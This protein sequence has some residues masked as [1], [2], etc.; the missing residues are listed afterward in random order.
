MEELGIPYSGPI[1]LFVDNRSAIDY[2]KNST[3]HGRAKHIDIQHHF[4]REKL[5]SKE[6]EINY[7]PT[8]DNLA[9]VL[10]KALPTPKHDIF[11]TR[12]HMATELRGSVVITPD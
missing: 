10:T 8:D 9:D 2:A 4:V 1:T 3:S 6:I 5:I 12:M 11:I 7:C